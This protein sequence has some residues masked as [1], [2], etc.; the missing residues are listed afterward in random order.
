MVV[1]GANALHKEPIM[2]THIQKESDSHGVKP[3]LYDPRVC[4]ERSLNVKRIQ[5]MQTKLTAMNPLIGFAYVIPSP[6]AIQMVDT[7]FG[8]H[9]LGSPLS[10]HLNAADFN[11]G[12]FSD[13]SKITDCKPSESPNCIPNLPLLPLR[14][15]EDTEKFAAALSQLSQEQRE[16]A[17]QLK[18]S[19]DECSAIEAR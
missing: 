17:V 6:S 11:F 19:N 3:T 18:V 13:L 15:N 12:I 4:S 16:F 10:F 7:K 14:F 2:S 1:S 5:E 8:K 9:A